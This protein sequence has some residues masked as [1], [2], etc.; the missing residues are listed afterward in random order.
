L[1]YEA[2]FNASFKEPATNRLESTT[3]RIASCDRLVKGLLFAGEA[4]L[5]APIS[6]TAGFAERFTEGGPRYQRGRSLGTTG[7]V[8]VATDSTR[9]V[10]CQGSLKDQLSSL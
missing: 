8:F 5:T 2:E 3:R 7:V 6:G 1:Q 10:A 4:L 9:D